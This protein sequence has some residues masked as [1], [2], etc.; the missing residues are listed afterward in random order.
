MAFNSCGGPGRST[1]ICPRA[2]SQSPGAVPRALSRTVAPSGTSA[3]RAFTV[4]IGRPICRKRASIL[5]MTSAL[6]SSF[7]PSKPATASRVR[8]SSVGPRPPLAI[9]SSARSIA[10]AN[11]SR[12]APS[13]SPTTVLRVTSTPS[14]FSCAVRKR[15]LVS[16]LSGVSSSD[17]TA[18]ISAFIVGLP[19]EWESLDVPI[20]TEESAVS[21]EDGAIP[22][23]GR[24]PP[25]A[26]AAEHLFGLAIGSD[27]HDAAAPGIRGGDVEISPAVKRKSLRPAQATEKGANLALLTDANHTIEAR[28]CGTGDKQLTSGTEREMIRRHGRLESCEHKN[29]SRGADLENRAAAVADEQVADGIERD[30][31]RGAHAFDPRLR[32]AIR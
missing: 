26:S 9:T 21:G 16:T 6:R 22:G 2:S 24:E 8:S 18:M 14:R 4:D 3:W 10:W 17:P 29:L 1:T 19:R 30:S 11:A 15:E 32:S 27:S 23:Q 25:E 13:S 12:R 28:C 20:E 5:L 31:R 7:R